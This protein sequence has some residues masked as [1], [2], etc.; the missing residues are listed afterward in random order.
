MPEVNALAVVVAAVA[1]F[2]ASGAWYV[3]FGDTMLSLQARWRGATAPEGP[4]AW[5][6][7]G[8]GVSGLV[9]AGAIAVLLD[10]ADA[11]G[12]PESVGIGLLVWVGFCATQ[13]V[14]SILGEDVPVG[15]A[16]I[17]AGDWLARLLIVTTIV[18]SWR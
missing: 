17:H 1:A 15:L 3:V 4:E 8:F 18:G 7:V 16:A 5:K 9:V 6:L 12:W 14:G 10:I 13:W 2:V 11:S